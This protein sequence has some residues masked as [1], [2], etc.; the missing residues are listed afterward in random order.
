MYVLTKYGNFVLNIQNL[1]KNFPYI[2]ESVS[3]KQLNL[4]KKVICQNSS[5]TVL[6]FAIVW[7]L[8][9]RKSTDK[10]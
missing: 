10:P 1:K 4:K 7:E 2:S 8:L 9:A 3:E 5:H 6:T